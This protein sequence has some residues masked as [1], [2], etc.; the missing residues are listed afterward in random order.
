MQRDVPRPV[1]A[2]MHQALSAAEAEAHGSLEKAAAA[3]TALV[4][5][6][7]KDNDD[8]LLEFVLTRGQHALAK[9]GSWQ[10]L[11]EWWCGGVHADVQG[12]AR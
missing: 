3:Y 1:R 7:A 10:G 6:A 4:T 2:A 9:L 12:G 5:D 11:R 8:T